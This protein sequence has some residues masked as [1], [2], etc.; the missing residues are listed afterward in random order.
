MNVAQTTDRT[1]VK[2]KSGTRHFTKSAD[3]FTNNK[4]SISLQESEKRFTFEHMSARIAAI[5]MVRGGEP[6][7]AKW[8]RWYGSLLGPGHLYIF[9]DGEDQVPPPCTAHCN[10]RV[11]PRV[12]GNVARGDR[13]RAG[14]LSSFA[15]TLLRSYDFVI[16]T[17]IDEFLCPDPSTGLDLVQYLS[18]L[19]RKGS[20]SFSALGCDVVQRMP[21]EGPMDWSKPMLGQRSH[22]LLSTRYTK[23][24]IL[25]APLKWG[26]GFH[27]VKGHNF[28]I[29]K[30]LYLFHFGCSD[31]A[32]QN[33]RLSDS[34]LASRGWSRHLGKRQRL[35]GLVAGM[36]PRS[37]ES[38]T[39]LAR[40]LQSAIRPPWAWNK[41]SM[42]GLRML[43]SI[44][45][46][47]FGLF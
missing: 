45:E 14:L 18:A 41:P 47:F 39:A 1:V 23:A 43:V 32:L 12:E 44:P 16:G 37:W 28:H 2:T 22:A 31:A 6:F 20:K 4:Y 29:A 21:E 36:Q 15:A 19:D 5:T 11:V 7:L 42:L 46:R 13:G 24:S 9:F 30:D 40:R 17:D 25:C 35:F 26:S 8:I 34:D 38:G 27:R 10:V 3:T 33:V